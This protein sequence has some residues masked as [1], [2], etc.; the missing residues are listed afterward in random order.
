MATFKK[1]NRFGDAGFSYN[2]VPTSYPNF[3]LFWGRTYHFWCNKEKGPWAS[4]CIFVL[5]SLGTLITC[6]LTLFRVRVPEGECI[7]SQLDGIWRLEVQRSGWSQAVQFL[8][9]YLFK[10]WGSSRELSKYWGPR[11]IPISFL[12]TFGFAYLE[13]LWRNQASS[14]GC[15]PLVVIPQTA[16]ADLQGSRTW[17]WRSGSGFHCLPRWQLRVPASVL[18]V[19]RTALTTLGFLLL[20]R[21][22]LTQWWGGR[23]VSQIGI[24]ISMSVLLISS[25]VTWSKLFTRLVPRFPYVWN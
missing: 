11:R 14:V 24:W 25:C 21:R 12:P 2:S 13:S 20:T 7:A 4:W 18:V 9:R 1:G 3:F 22:S 19:S 5:N 15:R 6:L 17:P 10:L 16:T 8:Y 23:I